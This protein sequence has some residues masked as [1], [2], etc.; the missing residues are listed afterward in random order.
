MPWIMHIL[1][2]LIIFLYS[3]IYHVII[4]ELGHVNH[5]LLVINSSINFL[6]YCCMAKRFR[7]ALKKLFT[8]RRSK[9]CCQRD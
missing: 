8:S 3:N 5:L 6:V 7:V 2:K 9:L 4:D 1:G